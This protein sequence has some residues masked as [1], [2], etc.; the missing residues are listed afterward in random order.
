MSLEWFSLVGKVALVT[1]AAQGI[2]RAITEAFAAAGARLVIADRQAEKLAH[3]ATALTIH[4]SA[5]AYNR[6]FM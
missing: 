6:G 5:T 4:H 1:G 3:T 2:G